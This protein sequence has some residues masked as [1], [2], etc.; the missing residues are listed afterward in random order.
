MTWVAAV[1][2]VTKP[3]VEIGWSAKGGLSQTRA[4]TQKCSSR[5]DCCCCCVLLHSFATHTSSVPLSFSFSR[6]SAAPVTQNRWIQTSAVCTF[7]YP[8]TYT[9]AS[10]TDRR[11]LF[12]ARPNMQERERVIVMKKCYK[13]STNERINTIETLTYN[14]RYL[15]R[16][17]NVWWVWQVLRP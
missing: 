5:A 4:L 13:Y 14:F 2:S 16:T 12:H 10:L 9:L 15:I 11:D 6:Q 8:S 1:A 7:C 3:V 17:I